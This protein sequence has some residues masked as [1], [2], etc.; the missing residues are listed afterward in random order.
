MKKKVSVI[1]N[2]HNGEKYLENCIKSILNQDYKNLEIILWDNNSTD[3][4]KAIVKK[5][6]D[7]R[8][9][10]FYNNKKDSLYKAR[11]KSILKS[12]GEFIAFLDSDDWW[13]KEYLSSRA[14]YFSDDKVDFFYCNT[15]FYFDESKKKKIYKKYNLP[16]GKIFDALAKDYFIIISGV[17]FKKKIFTKT[18]MFNENFNIIGDF[19]FLMKISKNFYAK[20]TNLPLINYRFHE[21]NLSKL[22]SQMFYDEY[23]SW[24][25]TNLNI[26]NNYLFEKNLRYFKK[27]LSYLEISNL[28]IENKK[29][30]YL[31]K[32]IFSHRNIYE[33]LKFLILLVTPHKFFKYLKK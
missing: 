10:Y 28:L 22:N 27:K 31:I 20:A 1:V 2:F 6:S 8:V 19:D 4:S 9:K 33:K 23:K 16:D 29:N 17:I 14:Q 5:F 21:K 18:G 32:K 12:T 24:F 25:E 26:S 30:L 15:N 7:T 13:E 3:K 11:N